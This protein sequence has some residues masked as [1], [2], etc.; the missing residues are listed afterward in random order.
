MLNE[1]QVLNYVKTKLGFPNLPLEYNDDQI[2]DYIRMNTIKEFSK[3][4]PDKHEV[5]LDVTKDEAQTEFRNV[6]RF[7]DP[8]D[9]TIMD[10]V[11]I[12]FSMAEWLI[13]GHPPIGL[14]GGG[15]EAAMRYV[16]QVDE[17]GTVDKW[18]YFRESYE[19]IP[20]NRVRIEPPP[21]GPV[22]IQYERHHLPDFSTIPP[23]YE[24]QFL[25]LCWADVA[26]WLGTIR[27]YFRTINTPFG[28]IELNADELISEAKEL[29]TTLIEMIS[30]Y[31]P[32]VIVD[33]G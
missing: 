10:I 4:I 17:A 24:K 12:Y 19:F 15:S 26:I 31:P 16:F 11:A 27:R 20:P 30:D 28:E 21:S 6:F 29:K 32:S 7:Y 25:D 8:D 13:A 18:S 23:E 22:T 5:P 9:A 1:Q 33:I 2:L 14:I 3:Y